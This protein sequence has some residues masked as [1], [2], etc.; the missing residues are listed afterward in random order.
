MALLLPWLLAQGLFLPAGLALIGLFVSFSRL[1]WICFLFGVLGLALLKRKG[2]WRSSLVVS[3]SLML[4]ALSIKLLPLSTDLSV[5]RRIELWESARAMIQT[6]PLFGI[7][8]GH[9]TAELP[10]FGLPSGPT[11]FLQPVHNIFA[12]I[13]AESGLFALAAVLVVFALALR[14][15]VRKRR[16]LL[17]VSLAQ[18][19][20]LGLFDHYLYTLPQ[21]LFLTS[22]TFGLIFGAKR[23]KRTFD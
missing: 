20:L 10:S 4:L 12:L 16:F 9:F 14:E 17:L 1:A 5:T 7:G 11:L 8:L 19:V 6:S 2:F 21:G 3:F 13:A 18:L 23:R 22:L 15:G